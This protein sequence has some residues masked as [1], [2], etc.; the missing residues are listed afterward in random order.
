MIVIGYQGIGKSTIAGKQGCVDLESGNFRVCDSG[1]RPPEW[2]RIYCN[3]AENL[4][5][6]GYT[7]LI[8]AHELVREALKSDIR[9]NKWSGKVVCIYPSLNLKC[10][11]ISK[12]LKRY[13]TTNLLKDSRAYVNAR[14]MYEEG[15]NDLAHSGFETIELQDMNY[16]LRDIVDRLQVEH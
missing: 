12:L 16:N 14:D 1:T 5:D 13:N 8:S 11:W 9:F 3:I 10:E 4:S 6:Q 15:I 2:Y 7:V